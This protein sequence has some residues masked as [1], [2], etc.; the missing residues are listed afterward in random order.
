M[1]WALNQR[2]RTIPGHHDCPWVSGMGIRVGLGLL[3]GMHRIVLEC[4]KFPVM[5]GDMS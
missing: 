4:H 3:G 2:G 1:I 5:H